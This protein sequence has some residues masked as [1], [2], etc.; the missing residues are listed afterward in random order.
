[1]CVAPFQYWQ[2]AYNGC[3]AVFRDQLA[4]QLPGEGRVWRLTDLVAGEG[5]NIEALPT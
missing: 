1:M 3:E 5:Q 4:E 2:H